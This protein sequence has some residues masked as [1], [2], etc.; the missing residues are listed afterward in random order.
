MARTTANPQS[1]ASSV[2]DESG[3]VRTS[4]DAVTQ[5]RVRSA[6]AAAGCLASPA[7]PRLTAGFEAA[8][9]RGTAVVVLP[10]DLGDADAATAVRLARESSP[11]AAVVV[12]SP[13]GRDSE[14]RRALRA[15]ASG[16]V[17]DGQLEMTL[18]PAVRAVAAG[19]VVVP[20]T[21]RAHILKPVFSH[22]EREVLRLVA[23]GSTNR[24]IADRL[25]L[26]ESTVKSHLSTA[27]TKLGV[28]TRAEA[29]ALVLDPGEQPIHGL[30]QG[31]APAMHDAPVATESEGG[32]N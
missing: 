30:W 5:R 32:S 12:V 10:I 20:R 18:A 3:I 1:P 9:D 22:R 28:R 14:V 13:A 2:L 21:L 26:A 8:G 16:I 23:E 27:F 6:L 19:F 4:G 11:G 17:F 25:F 24:E 31:G 7:E 15:G 29:A